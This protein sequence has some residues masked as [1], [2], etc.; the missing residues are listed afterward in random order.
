M[1]SDADM[2]GDREGEVLFEG[3]LLDEGLCDSDLLI[4]G[5]MEGETDG[6]VLGE[7]EGG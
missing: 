6:L 4:E 7:V 1:L 3:V 2:L 5:V